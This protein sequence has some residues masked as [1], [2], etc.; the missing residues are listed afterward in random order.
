MADVLRPVLVKGGNDYCTKNTETPDTTPNH[1]TVAADCKHTTRLLAVKHVAS[2]QATCTV[3]V[4][5]S[6]RH[7]VPHGILPAK[8]VLSTRLCVTQSSCGLEVRGQ[9][10]AFNAMQP[11]WLQARCRIC[12]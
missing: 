11:G 3:G 10:K 9:F 7:S 6:L 1:I 2:H 12:M 8:K 4:S 5:C